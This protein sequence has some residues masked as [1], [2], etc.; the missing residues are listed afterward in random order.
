M[1]Q[2]QLGMKW[3]K[4]IIYFALWAG[5]V[6]NVISAISLMTGSI[7]EDVGGSAEVVYSVFP[8]LK[9][10]DIFFG[11]IL[12]FIAIYQIYVR[13][14]LV[15]FKAKAPMMLVL[16]YCIL[17][18]YEVLYAIVASSFLVRI[19]GDPTIADSI[20]NII[21][22]IIMAVVNYKYFDNRDELF[23]Y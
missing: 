16:I 15:K 4:F 13:S 8:G 20:P 23:V 19:G 1:E 2:R 11:V 22:W 18:A 14:C 17:I 6:F 7:Y 12:I 9:G 10:W 3:Y 21:G 5:A